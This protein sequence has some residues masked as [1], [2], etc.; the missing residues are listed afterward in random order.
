MKGYVSFNYNFTPCCNCF[1]IK[2]LSTIPFANFSLVF[3]C[4]LE[5]YFTKS[6]I[7]LCLWLSLAEMSLLRVS[8]LQSNFCSIFKINTFFSCCNNSNTIYHILLHHCFRVSFR[9]KRWK[10]MQ[11]F[12]RTPLFLLYTPVHGHHQ[13]VA[14]TWSGRVYF[15][16]MFAFEK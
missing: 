10:R 11:I 15:A 8:Q 12:S 2:P 6:S 14:F 5:I 9:I 3:W 1:L 16:W 7:G 13:R 4:L